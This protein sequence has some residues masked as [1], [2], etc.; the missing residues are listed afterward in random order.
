M[1]PT[2][3]VS[4]LFA[5]LVLS[6]ATAHSAVA[7]CP[8]EGWDRE[9]LLELKKSEFKIAEAPERQALALGLLACLA[10]P[11]PVLR[12]GVAFEGWSKWLRADQLSEE[13]RRAATLELL[14]LLAANAVDEAGFRQP[15]AA[16]VLAELARSERKTPWMQAAERQQL[17]EAAALYVESVRDYRGF[18]DVQGWRNGVAHGADL[19]MQLALNPALHKGQ[20]DRILAAVKSQVAP[21]GSHSYIHGEPARLA[22]PALFVAMTGMYS[23]EQ[24]AAWLEPI[25]APAPLVAWSDAFKS[26]E[27]MARR[28]NTR[29][30]LLEMYLAANASK[31]ETLRALLPAI[32]KAMAMVP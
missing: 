31:D 16:L 15:F 3:P 20:L 7:A 27:G 28:H 8:P 26:S 13:T 22:R 11:D 24:F 18:D 1:H 19:L 12:D 2:R 23:T 30:F 25:A 5:V 6:L 32:N 14:P 10:D 4:R 17:L 21:A 9:R 29:T